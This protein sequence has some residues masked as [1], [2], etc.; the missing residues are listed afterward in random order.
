[1]R[2]TLFTTNSTIF[3][4]QEAPFPW[5]EFDRVHC[6]KQVARLNRSSK[7]PQGSERL[8]EGTE[9]NL[10][11]LHFLPQDFA[12]AVDPEAHKSGCTRRAGDACTTEVEIRISPS[13]PMVMKELWRDNSRNISRIELRIIP[14]KALLYWLQIFANSKM[15]VQKACKVSKYKW[16]QTKYLWDFDTLS[17][18][19]LQSS[20]S[21][22]RNWSLQ[23]NIR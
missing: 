13:S 10:G 18:Q 7:N 17:G 2:F 15:S 12:A 16:Q 20:F 19:T 14:G 5:T 8:W 23:P 9:E 4:G 11:P 6:F 22:Y 1:M 3:V 21:L